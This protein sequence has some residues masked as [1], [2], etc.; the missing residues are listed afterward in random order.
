MENIKKKSEQLDREKGWH[1]LSSTH[2]NNQQRS[3]YVQALLES[4]GFWSET[5]PLSTVCWLFV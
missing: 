2:Q 5:T 4:A 1:G 3:G